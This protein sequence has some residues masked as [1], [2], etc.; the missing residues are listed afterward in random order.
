M[1]SVL[2]YVYGVKVQTIFVINGSVLGFLYVILIP[3]WMHLKCIWYDRSSG[4]IEG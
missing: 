1:I 3:I 2:V 4:T